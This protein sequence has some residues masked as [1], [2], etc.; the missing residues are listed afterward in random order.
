MDNIKKPSLVEEPKTFAANQLYEPV[1]FYKLVTLKEDNAM[2]DIVKEQVRI[3][4]SKGRKPKNRLERNVFLDNM[5]SKCTSLKNHMETAE[6]FY[7]QLNA[8]AF[9]KDRKQ[10]QNQSKGPNTRVVMVP[11]DQEVNPL[12]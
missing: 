2:E 5:Q 3:H 4:K 11:V 7:N 1:K 12:L 8:Q 6:K 10:G 9:K